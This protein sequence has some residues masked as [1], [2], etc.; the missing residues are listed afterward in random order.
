[1]NTTAYFK[2]PDMSVQELFELLLKAKQDL[3]SK[4][5][6]K[7]LPQ[8]V[9]EAVFDFDKVNY[10]RE[11]KDESFLKGR[12]ENSS[13]ITFTL[14]YSDEGCILEAYAPDLLDLVIELGWEQVHQDFPDEGDD[15]FWL[16]WQ[17]NPSHN[18]LKME[19]FPED[20]GDFWKDYDRRPPRMYYPYH[21]RTDL[22][23]NV[24]IPNLEER[25]EVLYNRMVDNLYYQHPYGKYTDLAKDVTKKMNEDVLQL[26]KESLKTDLTI[27]DLYCKVPW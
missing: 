8:I 18:V 3:K 23:F 24:H 19:I 15:N 22:N 1:M 26:T 2:L 5:E 17:D 14:A 25:H 12:S 13:L 10:I 6:L 9:R 16:L 20:H 21:L 7:Y 4:I 11:V 27:E